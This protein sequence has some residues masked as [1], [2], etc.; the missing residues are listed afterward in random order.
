MH[1]QILWWSAISVVLL[2]HLETHSK[3]FVCYG[4]LLSKTIIRKSCYLYCTGGIAGILSIIKIWEIKKPVSGISKKSTCLMKSKFCAKLKVENL[5]RIFLFIS[6]VFIF[7][8]CEKYRS[9]YF[10]LQIKLWLR[11]R[12]GE[13]CHRFIASRQHGRQEVRTRISWPFLERLRSFLSRPL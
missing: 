13:I 6:S 8:Q 5:H 7:V 10:L 1:L 4:S 2:T 12:W 3:T 11:N 9:R